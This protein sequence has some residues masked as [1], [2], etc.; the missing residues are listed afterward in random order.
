MGKPR[1]IL[2]PIFNRAHLG[3]L[4]PV[5]S[6]IRKNP[7][8][9]L[10]II[11]GL[12]AAYGNFWLNLKHSRPA[13]WKK[14][15]PWY[16]RARLS[17]FFKSR[18]LATLGNNNFLVEAL[19]REGFK[20]NSFLPLFFDGGLS[21]IMAKSV[22]LGLIGI[23][24]ELKRLEPDIVFVN[25][26][27]FEMMAVALAASYMNILVAHNEAGDVS[28]TID[29]GIRHAITKLSHIH[30]TASEKSRQR[31]LQMGENPE[32]VFNVGSP[33]IDAVKSINTDGKLKTLPEF[34]LNER[35]LLVLLHPVATE[36]REHNYLAIKNLVAVL[37]ELK[38]PTIFLGSNID[39]GSAEIAK[40]TLKL[41]QE[42]PGFM[43]LV[44]NLP[45]DDFYLALA[46]TS[47]AIGNSSSFIREGAFLGTPVVLV[48]SR[49]QGRDKGENAI[50]S[51][52]EPERI[53]RKILF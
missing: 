11:V 22:G 29:E 32:F 47:C 19:T 26:D 42:K 52:A 7:L 51:E 33:A 31:V 40:I 28:G 10:Q 44:K 53:K 9:E 23:T 5:L 38:M 25:A 24:D 27:R 17:Y 36:D 16:L 41:R 6:A 2:V 35:F 37:D 4:K 43:T 39:A 21:E 15:L 20:I 30:F 13:S 14:S 46:R 50:E 1:K 45:A 18:R 34:N 3:R 8:L 12:P 48:G 49:Q